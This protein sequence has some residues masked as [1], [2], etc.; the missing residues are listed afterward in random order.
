MLQ[1]DSNVRRPQLT[2]LGWIHGHFEGLRTELHFRLSRLI[3][4]ERLFRAL[5]LPKLAVLVTDQGRRPRNAAGTQDPKAEP[6]PVSSKEQK[7]HMT[8]LQEVTHRGKTREFS[9]FAHL[10]L[11]AIKTW[12]E[13][14]FVDTGW[15]LSLGHSSARH[16]AKTCN[17]LH[18]LSCG[19][20]LSTG[21]GALASQA[22]PLIWQDAI[23]I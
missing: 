6:R 7:N 15:D 12:K 23:S 10:G 1:G 9:N 13:G 8:A 4:A 22:L 5:G 11:A 17:R 19:V 2:A 18:G 3:D 20:I 14:Q 16:A 21:H